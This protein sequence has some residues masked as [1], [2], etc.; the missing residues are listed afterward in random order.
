MR[1][2][3]LDVFTSRS[4]SPAWGFLD[5]KK[6]TETEPG[7]TQYYGLGLHLMV[8]RAP[9]PRLRLGDFRCNRWQIVNA[10]ARLTRPIGW[11]I[12]IT[13]D[14][15]GCDLLDFFLERHSRREFEFYGLG[16]HVFGSPL[17]LSRR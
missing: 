7:C 9:L 5:F 15:R 6:D 8:C 13:N 10:M 1:L 16:L 11:D 2:V 12:F 3:G 17:R 14:D 4:S